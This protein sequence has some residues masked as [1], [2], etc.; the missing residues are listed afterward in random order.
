[1]ARDHDE[2]IDEPVP[3]AAEDRAI[4][5]LLAAAIPGARRVDLPGSKRGHASDPRGF[6]AEMMPFLVQ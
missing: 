6:C 5:D 2:K 4:L 1:M 3:L